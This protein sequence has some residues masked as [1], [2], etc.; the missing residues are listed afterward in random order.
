MVESGVGTLEGGCQHPIER[1]PTR[2]VERLSRAS[3]EV[4]IELIHV[5][6]VGKVFGVDIVE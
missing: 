6:R 2:R 4:A 5:A 1:Q 3:V